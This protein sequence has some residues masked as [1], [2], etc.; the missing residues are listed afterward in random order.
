MLLLPG[1]VMNPDTLRMNPSAVAFVKAFVGEEVRVRSE[2]PAVAGRQA[3]V[4]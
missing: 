3:R 4:P 1:G 2:R